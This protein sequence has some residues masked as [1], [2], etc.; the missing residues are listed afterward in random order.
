M[1]TVIGLL[2]AVMSLVL[3]SHDML[4]V[5]TTRFDSGGV[6]WRDVYGILVAVIILPQFIVLCVV[7]LSDVP[8]LIAVQATSM[9][10]TAVAAV[11]IYRKYNYA[12]TSFP[13]SVLSVVDDHVA[14]H[15]M[16][17]RYA[18]VRERQEACDDVRTAH[19]VHFVAVPVADEGHGHYHGVARGRISRSNSTSASGDGSSNSGGV[20]VGVGGGGDDD[21]S[22][23]GGGAHRLATPLVTAEHTN[24]DRDTGSARS[25]R[26]GAR[27]RLVVVPPT[28]WRSTKL[29]N[30]CIGSRAY[31]LPATQQDTMYANRPLV[32]ALRRHIDGSD[33]TASPA[34]QQ[35]R[36]KAK[37]R[38]L[39]AAAFAYDY[40]HPVLRHARNLTSRFTEARRQRDRE[41]A[42]ALLIQTVARAK[43]LKNVFLRRAAPAAAP[44]PAVVVVPVED[45]EEEGQFDVI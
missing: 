30:D 35:R 20:G 8:W 23:S 38:E 33:G 25:R 6:Y 44:A 5:G 32:H 26:N 41:N 37:R 19:A 21:D 28:V 14:S 45:D 9:V 7:A 16:L 12:A 40:H 18:D 43:L 34:E 4:A 27:G 22:A 10:L 1:I 17:A 13:Q 11:V 2:Y 15:M 42:A 29:V 24:E 31:L 39:L 3:Y 36:E